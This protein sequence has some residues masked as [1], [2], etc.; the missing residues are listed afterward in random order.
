MNG[1]G[2]GYAHRCNIGMN[3]MGLAKHFLFGF[4]VNKTELMSGTV[5][6]AQNL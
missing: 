6:S 4:K 1:R 3:V 5:N 2:G